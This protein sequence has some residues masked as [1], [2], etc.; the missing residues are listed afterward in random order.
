MTKKSKTILEF[1]VNTADDRQAEDIVALDVQGIS[2]L[3]DYFVIMNGNSSRQNQAIMNALIADAEK[4]GIEVKKVEGRDSPSWTLIDFN[5][6]IVHIFS[7]EDREFYNL[8]KLW[9]DAD[10]VNIDLMIEEN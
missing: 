10:L 1:V 7:K 6:V 9:S 3:A 2:I 5:D 8:E 4:K